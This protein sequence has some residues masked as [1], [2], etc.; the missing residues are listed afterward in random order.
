[1]PRRFLARHAPALL[2]FVGLTMLLVFPLFAQLTTAIP[3]DEGDNL[4]YVRGL[5]WMKRALVDLHIAPFFDPTAYHPVGHVL[6]R[7]EM[8]VANSIPALPLTIFLGPVV[9]YNAVLFFSFVATGFFT[10]LWVR[11]LTG[12]RAAGLLAGTIA[13]FLPF[14]F[15]HLP[16]HLPQMTS[17]WLP[18]TLLAFERFLAQRTP[19][20]AAFLGLAGGLVT[21]GSWY[22]GYSL[23]IMLP[24]YA[25][26]R[27]WSCRHVWRESA[28]WRGLILSSIVA[29]V[30][31]LPFLIPMVQLSCE[32]VLK[33]DIAELTHFSLNFYDFFTPNL[34]HPLWGDLIEERFP[35]QRGE[36]V[37]R[38]VTLGY[39]AI[40]AALAGLL[41]RQHRPMV[42]GL[43]VVWAVSY[44]IALGPTLHAG[45]QEVRV[46]VLSGEDG[47]PARRSILLPS[48][49]MYH[50]V[51]FTSSMRVMARFAVWTGLMTAALAGWGLLRLMD[52]AERRWG[53]AARGVVAA[54]L[55]AGVAFESRSK[56]PMLT[57]YSRPVDTWLAAQPDDTVIVELP[58]DQALRP[59][60]NYWA[61]VNHRRNLFSWN[62]DSF[63][64]AVQTQYIRELLSFPS[65]ASVAFLRRLG[66]TYVLLTPNRIVSWPTMEPQVDGLDGLRLERTIGDVRVYRVLPK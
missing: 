20:R 45:D 7:S 17:Q 33:R 18:L 12:S 47:K 27:T 19:G 24:V 59:F 9:S 44:S 15:A 53:R 34:A 6:A 13:A 23:A 48:W 62:S 55:I 4:Y 25:V 66:V 14:R 41:W 11:H 21:L 8:N 39:V 40:A 64:P 58:V 1:M 56:V 30:L 61:T 42:I 26:C 32:G 35:G 16:G 38:G 36:W 22:Y 51:P 5:W 63:P 57:V 37:E 2:L 50:V 29:V 28:W 60:Q 3:G 10:Y 65:Q 46:S 43:L 52:G 54:A 49:F 31:V